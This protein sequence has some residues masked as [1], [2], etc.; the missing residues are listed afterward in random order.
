MF[1]KLSVVPECVAAKNQDLVA[2]FAF[3][4]GDLFVSVC[5]A[6]DAGIMPGLR[7]LWDQAV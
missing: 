4:F 6:D 1:V 5:A 3:E 2:G 7:L